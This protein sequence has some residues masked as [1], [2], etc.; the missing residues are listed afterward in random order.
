MLVST[1]RIQ[2]DKKNIPLF[3]ASDVIF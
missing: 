2:G 3:E 1:L